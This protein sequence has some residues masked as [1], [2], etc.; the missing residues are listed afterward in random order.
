MKIL[1]V[2]L[3]SLLVFSGCTTKTVYVDRPVEVLVPSE[4]KLV[5]PER[6]IK[7]SN[8]AESLLNILKHR[9]KLEG[10]VEAYK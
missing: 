1:I 7:G 4:C 6:A 9:D 10:I 5:A 2:L 3:T 8:R